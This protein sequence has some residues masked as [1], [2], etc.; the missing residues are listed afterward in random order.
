MKR[1]VTLSFLFLILL[2]LPLFGGSRSQFGTIEQALAA[3]SSDIVNHADAS[4]PLHSSPIMRLHHAGQ[5]DDDARL[6]ARHAMGTKSPLEDPH[7][8]TTL[9]KSELEVYIPPELLE[10]VNIK[11]NHE[12]KTVV[13][14]SF[15]CDNVS[16]IPQTE[17]E[18]LVALYKS[19]NGPNWTKNDGWLTTDTPCNWH[20]VS[21][22]KGHVS[23]LALGNNQLSGNIPVELGQLSNLVYLYLSWNQLSG[24]IPP[25]LG[26]LSNLQ[27]LYLSYNQL[28][29]NIPPQLSQLSNLINYREISLLN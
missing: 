25:Q 11:P 10:E 17:C 21:C 4:D 19:T 2:L 8:I 5:F 6:Q 12:G 27:S 13:S 1:L 23:G 28:S 20:R 14:G 9:S 16:Q 18:A 15:S 26:Q 24:D 3:Q 29:G 7:S 22:D